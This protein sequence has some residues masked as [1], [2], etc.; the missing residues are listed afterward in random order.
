M[1]SSDAISSSA[2]AVFSA[3]FTSVAAF[4]SVSSACAAS[5]VSPAEVW[6]SVPAKTDSLLSL[7]ASPD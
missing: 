3:I 6:A 7:K 4:D 1:L 5:T 2:I